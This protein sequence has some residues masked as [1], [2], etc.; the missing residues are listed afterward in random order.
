MQRTVP[1]I[2]IL[3]LIVFF[4]LYYIL[5]N[6]AILNQYKILSNYQPKTYTKDQHVIL[7]WTKFFAVPNWGLPNETVDHNYFIKQKCPKTNCIIT[8]NR[9]HLNSIIDYDAILFHGA[10]IFPIIQPTP[11]ERSPDQLYVFAIQ[12]SPAET[13][14]NLK[15]DYDFFNLTMS[16]RLDS[17]ILWPYNGIKDIQSNIVIAPNYMP[18]WREPDNIN[19]SSNEYNELIKL[20]ENKNKI[21]AWFVSRCNVL[22][23]RIKLAYEL[24]KYMTIDI[25]GKCGNLTCPRGSPICDKLL[26][27]NYKFYF[28]FENSLCIDY[29]T[30]KLYNALKRKI[31]PVVFGGADYMRFAPPKSYINAEHF[32]TI[33][34]LADYLLY[35]DKNPSEYIKY[36]WWKKHYKVEINHNTGFCQLC[37]FLN[38]PNRIN[39]KQIYGDIENWWLG[40]SC[41]LKPKLKEL[42]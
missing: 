12:E 13:K 20:V 5:Y 34:D 29:V 40:N 19:N 8:S 14:H 35:L 1:I 16:Y 33:K 36:F 39:R 21:G 30:E 7:L 25:Y 22:A 31:V 6:S 23:N 32:D 26:D 11:L 3:V 17:D 37:T 9:D 15:T 27:E 42:H 24:Q 41:R 2:I 4:L 28:S 10:E 18:S 38:Q